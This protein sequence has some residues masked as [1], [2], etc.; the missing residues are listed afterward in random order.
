MSNL[1][2]WIVSEIKHARHQSESFPPHLRHLFK[3]DI[4]I[5]EVVR[6]SPKAG[7]AQKN[8]RRTYLKKKQNPHL[9]PI[10]YSD[11]VTNLW[12]NFD[13][14]INPLLYKYSLSGGEKAPDNFIQFSPQLEFYK[15]QIRKE[16][17]HV[18]RS[19]NPMR[20]SDSTDEECVDNGVQCDLKSDTSENNTKIHRVNLHYI[21]L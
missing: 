20:H 12:K 3:S 19:S 4:K 11:K 7:N 10:Q 17:F 2:T 18:R 1:P 16:P 8:T 6:N 5:P 15:R 14:S 21:N 13:S 9:K